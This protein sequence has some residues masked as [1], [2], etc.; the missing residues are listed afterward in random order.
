MK[1]YILLILFICSSS[2][3]CAQNSDGFFVEDSKIKWV[4]VFDTD[5][6]VEQIKISLI[7]SGIFQEIFLE[8]EDRLTGISKRMKSLYSEMGYKVLTTDFMA[9]DV[10]IWG[11][12]T[13]QI[14][15]G[16]YRATIEDIFIQSPLKSHMFG[17]SPREVELIL[18]KR[19]GNLRGRFNNIYP[20]WEYTFI[21]NLTPTIIDDDW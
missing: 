1:K 21:K 6:N 16:R 3:V 13:I 15:E 9:G 7:E 2:F 12:L 11:K 5:G 4:K 20:I 17:D 19:D 10:D 18:L 8:R 14:R